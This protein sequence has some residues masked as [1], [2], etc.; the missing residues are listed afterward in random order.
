M[1]VAPQKTLRER[2]EEARLGGEVALKDQSTDPLGPPTP[3]GSLCDQYVAGARFRVVR[4]GARLE[5]IQLFGEKAW[6]GFAKD[7]SVGDVVICNGW[8]TGMD[9]ETREVNFTAQGVPWAAQW[10]QVWPQ[11]GLWKP[12]P[13][14]GTLEPVEET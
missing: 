9:G 6:A 11:A 13:L 7:L 10:V 12:W 1:T 8:R 14:P 2:A 5:G 4:E 3:R